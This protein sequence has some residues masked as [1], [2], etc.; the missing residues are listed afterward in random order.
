[1]RPLI[2]GSSVVSNFLNSLRSKY[3]VN[4]HDMCHKKCIQKFN[5]YTSGKEN[6]YKAKKMSVR[7]Y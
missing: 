1:M 6:T 7:Q 2:V 4:A 5:V 3:C